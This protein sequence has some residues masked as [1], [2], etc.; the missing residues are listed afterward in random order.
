MNSD[1]VTAAVLA[2][3]GSTRMG[4]DKALLKLGNKTMIER[5]VIPLQGVFK[6]YGNQR[7]GKI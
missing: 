4:Q 6:N 1:R 5:V 7:T 3:G 2:G